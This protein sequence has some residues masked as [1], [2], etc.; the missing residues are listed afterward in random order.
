[1]F[2]SEGFRANAR[3]FAGPVRVGSRHALR[4]LARG[5]TQPI[6]PR[7]DPIIVGKNGYAGAK[8]LKLI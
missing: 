8:G 7:D 6:S 1:M 5:T 4:R 3:R 2:V